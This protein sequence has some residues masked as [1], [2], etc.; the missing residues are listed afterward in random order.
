MI[1][2]QWLLKV[3][4]WCITDDNWQAITSV[5]SARYVYDIKLLIFKLRSRIDILS[6]S[7]KIALRWMPQDL[8]DD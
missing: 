3:V 1:N 8:T 6:I 4:A 7:H 5:A 2:H